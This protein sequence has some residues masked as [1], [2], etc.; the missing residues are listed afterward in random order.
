MQKLQPPDLGRDDRFGHAV[1]L[2]GDLALVAA[3][4][5]DAPGKPNAGCVYVFRREVSG[6][7]QVGKLQPADL[8]RNDYFGQSLA[9]DDRLVFVGTYTQNRVYVFGE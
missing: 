9:V 2:Q 8:Q 3:N 7:R 4:H 1:A 6:W 5:A